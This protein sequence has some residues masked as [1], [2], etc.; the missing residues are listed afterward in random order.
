MTDN[1]RIFKEGAYQIDC[2]K[3]IFASNGMRDY[4]QQDVFAKYQLSD[5]DWVI[6]D[7]IYIYI[8]KNSNVKAVLIGNI[9]KLY[10]SLYNKLTRKKPQTA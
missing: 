7:D 10:N 2:S 9:I 5:V 6:E 1:N 4:Y 3:A 8:L